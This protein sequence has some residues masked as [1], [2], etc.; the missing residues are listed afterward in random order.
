MNAKINSKGSNIN[1]TTIVN[2]EN[3][4]NGEQQL[5]NQTDIKFPDNNIKPNCESSIMMN[6]QEKQRKKDIKNP[7]KVVKDIKANNSNENPSYS[8]KE[9][10]NQ[11]QN[12][13]NDSDSENSNDDGESN[14]D[15]N[16]DDKDMLK[17]KNREAAKKHRLKKASFYKHIEDENKLLKDLI[18]KVYGEADIL[19]IVQSLNIGAEVREILNRAD[20]TDVGLKSI[21]KRNKKDDNNNLALNPSEREFE[22][23]DSRDKIIR[24]KFSDPDTISECK[25]IKSP[26]KSEECNVVNY[27]H[28]NII[29]SS[30]IANN[31]IKNTTNNNTNNDKEVLNNNQD[32]TLIS[33]KTNKDTNNKKNNKKKNNKNNDNEYPHSYIEVEFADSLDKNSYLSKKRGNAEKKV[34]NYV[35]SNVNI[36]NTNVKNTVTSY[37]SNVID[38]YK[39]P[40][41]GNVVSNQ[42]SFF[43][44]PQNNTLNTNTNNY[45]N[46]TTCNNL[47]NPYVYNP[48]ALNLIHNNISNTSFNSTFSKTNNNMNNEA[49]NLKNMNNGNSD[50]MPVNNIST[51]NIN[52]YEANNKVDTSNMTINENFS[53]INNNNNNDDNNNNPNIHNLQANIAYY[54]NENSY[55]NIKNKIA[56]NNNNNDPYSILNQNNNFI[57]ILINMNSEQGN[58]SNNSEKN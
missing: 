51:Q 44:I 5:N 33:N 3:V 25:E 49:K 9:M 45:N 39:F 35:D 17:K 36:E 53:N 23:N 57:N 26:L 55:N 56:N 14:M 52:N 7:F 43:N 58:Y 12:Q 54:N 32:L 4:D 31:S 24:K 30:S 47:I 16:R 10:N 8:Y 20:T 19:T 41:L 1:I 29:Y 2:Q 40:L 46:I 27:A 13:E 42:S 21:T 50:M 15:D 18:K 37:N 6:S 22:I 34:V 28:N 38:H 11:S 48:S